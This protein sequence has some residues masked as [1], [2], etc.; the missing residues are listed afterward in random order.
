[1]VN[2]PTPDAARAAPATAFAL[3]A[4]ALATGTAAL[5]LTLAVLP[6]FVSEGPR[7]ALMGLFRLACHQQR[8][9]SFVFDGVPF[10]L[11]HRCTGVVAGLALGA[12]FLPLA[13]RWPTIARAWP[14]HRA[15]GLLACAALFPGL[16]WAL[17]VLGLWANTPA[18]RFATGLAFGLVAGLILTRAALRA[19][20]SPPT[21][22]GWAE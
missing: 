14:K 6:P 8:A 9:R 20:A 22:A 3:R 7:R 12:T 13:F 16:D 17:G 11:C 21:A 18:S 15:A 10:A 4:W 19:D 2:R 5:V 1:M